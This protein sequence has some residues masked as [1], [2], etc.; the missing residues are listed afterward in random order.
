M[1]GTVQ[2]PRPRWRRSIVGVEY[3]SFYELLCIKHFYIF[4]PSIFIVILVNT[5][6]NSIP[7]QHVCR[8]PS[9][10]S[11]LKQSLRSI[12]KICFPC[13]AS[14]WP[15]C[16]LSV[17]LQHQILV[18][19]FRVIDRYVRLFR[20]CSQRLVNQW[21]VREVIERTPLILSTCWLIV[22]C[23]KGSIAM[24]LVQRL[25]LALMAI[26]E[27]DQ[28]NLWLNPRML[29]SLGSVGIQLGTCK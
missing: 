7:L 8:D 20:P 6:F 14:C 16:F 29:S 2:P 21:L 24:S 15:L 27:K 17:D 11:H 23:S 3:V 10:G 13:L 28:S 26:G 1:R 22:D 12:G 4:S 19:E 5:P 9:D 25:F 18:Q